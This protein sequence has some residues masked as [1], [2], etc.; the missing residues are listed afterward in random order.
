MLTIISVLKLRLLHLPL[1]TI[2]VTPWLFIWNR[3][4]IKHLSSFTNNI[5]HNG[6]GITRILFSSSYILFSLWY[7]FI[8][9]KIQATI[10][11]CINCHTYSWFCAFWTDTCEQDHGSSY[12]NI[13]LSTLPYHERAQNGS[14][15]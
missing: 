12:Q 2:F 4:P 7:I 3:S 5:R 15:G 8:S 6:T 11:L 1:N 10:N 9:H 13:T 14:P